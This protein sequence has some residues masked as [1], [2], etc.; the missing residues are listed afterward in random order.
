VGA[1]H[2]LKIPY[3]MKAASAIGWK[4]TQV[5]INGLLLNRFEEQIEK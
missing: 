3:K 4:T 2:F 1:V 5:N